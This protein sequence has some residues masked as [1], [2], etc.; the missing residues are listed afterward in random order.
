MSNKEKLKEYSAYLIGQEKSKITIEKYE[1]D[2]RRFLEYTDGRII[3]KDLCIAYKNH[4]IDKGYALTTVNSM[5]ASIDNYLNYIGL[6]NLKVKPLKVQHQIFEHDSRELTKAEYER[7]LAAAKSHPRLYMIIKTICATG[8]RVSELRYF[9]V[10]KVV[11][12]SISVDGKCKNREV[13][14]PKRLCNQLIAYAVQNNIES[15]IIFRTNTGKPLDRSDIHRSMKNLYMKADIN[16]NKI[17]PHNLRK[18]FARTFYKKEKDIARLADVLGH[19]DINT[20]RIYIKT[21][22]KEQQESID[23]LGL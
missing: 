16:R 13:I 15:G 7:L 14:I 18:L 12:G 8:I 20:T 3:T 23:S 17:F 2:V 22:L 10:D 1:R 5:L 11:R 4:I 9:T 6:S 21:T 19:S